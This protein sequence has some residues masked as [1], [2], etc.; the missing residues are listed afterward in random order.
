MIKSIEYTLKGD[1]QSMTLSRDEGSTKV[2][3]TFHHYN[4]CSLAM[5]DFEDLKTA[6]EVLTDKHHDE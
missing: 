6:V 1:F 3:L 4:G 2:Q 5:F